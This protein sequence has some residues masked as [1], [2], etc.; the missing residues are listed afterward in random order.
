MLC[1]YVSGGRGARAKHCKNQCETCFFVGR[2][3]AHF[4]RQHSYR[5]VRQEK[6]KIPESKSPKFQK[7]KTKN[8][9]FI[10]STESCN[11]IGFL[12]FSI[13]RFL[14]F[15]I[16]GFL[17]VRSFGFLVFVVFSG[18]FVFC[19]FVVFCFWYTSAVSNV[20]LRVPKTESDFRCTEKAEFTD[21]WS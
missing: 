5:T 16:F 11:K 6:R 2:I 21:Y 13:F 8:P 19:L 9:K 4:L 3:S 10:T 7:S 20:F 15:W 14:D 18:G 12:E 17:D 1:H